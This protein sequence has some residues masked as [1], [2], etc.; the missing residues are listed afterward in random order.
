MYRRKCLL[1][2]VYVNCSQVNFVLKVDDDVSVKYVPITWPIS[3]KL[4]FTHP[5]SYYLVLS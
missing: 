2:W 1:N 3:S 4:I 5:I